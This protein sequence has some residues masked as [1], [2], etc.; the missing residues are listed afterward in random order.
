MSCQFLFIQPV[1]QRQRL[2][3]KGSCSVTASNL[4]NPLSRNT[5]SDNR[6][7]LVQTESAFESAVSRVEM[8]EEVGQKIRKI[9]LLAQKEGTMQR[10]WRTGNNNSALGDCQQNITID[11]LVSRGWQNMI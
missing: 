3:S 9:T 1:S 2:F 11:Y 8:W 6:R 5:R 7:R 4:E 10:N